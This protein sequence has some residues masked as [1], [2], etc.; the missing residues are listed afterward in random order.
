MVDNLVP[1]IKDP[2]TRKGA[3]MID[4]PNEDIET[5]KEFYDII[6]FFQFQKN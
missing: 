1:N 2:R 6:D 3:Y 4:N 5:L